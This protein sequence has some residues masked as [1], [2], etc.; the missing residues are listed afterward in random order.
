MTL[1]PSLW[2]L[3][4]N[5]RQKQSSPKS[6]ELVVLIDFKSIVG[7]HS[8]TKDNGTL[9]PSLQKATHMNCYLINY[10]KWSENDKNKFKEQYF[11]RKQVNLSYPS[12]D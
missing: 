7:V 6:V 2:A 3:G 11:T 10:E 4:T 9:L 1:L 5:R 12:L 8:R